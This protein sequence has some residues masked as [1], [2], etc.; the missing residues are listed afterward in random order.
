MLTNNSRIANVRGWK[1]GHSWTFTIKSQP[2]YNWFVEYM[3]VYDNIFCG[4][5]TRSD[6]YYPG[7]VLGVESIRKGLTE[8]VIKN[9]NI[10]KFPH[11]EPHRDS[12]HTKNIK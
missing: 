11:N 3:V 5:K 4:Y 9:D 2:S 8:C 12:R 10:K 1:T 7:S 6:E